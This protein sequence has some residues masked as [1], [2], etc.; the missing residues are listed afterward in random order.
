MSLLAAS[1]D[2]I[3]ERAAGDPRWR[4]SGRASM[5]ASV[6]RISTKAASRRG[7]LLLAAL[8]TLAASATGSLKLDVPN[9]AGVKGTAEI[10]AGNGDKAGEVAPGATIA[11]PPGKYRLVL[12]MVGGRITKDSVIIAAGRTSTV[13]IAN[14]AVLSV[15]VKDRD[16]KE[17]GFGVTVTGT[18]PPHDKVAEFPSGEAILMAP[19]QVDVKVDA[20]PQGY[21][22]HAVTLK[23]GERANL[24]L[25]EVMPAELIVHPQRA[26]IPLD[27]QT[28]VVVYKAGT[29]SQIGASEPGSEHRFKLEPGDYDVYVENHSGAG[30]PYAT[31]RGIHLRGG[32]TVERKIALDAAPGASHTSNDGGG[33]NH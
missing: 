16:G 2:S 6:F 9:S 29:Q 20:P 17:P 28:R 11:L 27:K 32:D 10:Y 12:P 23:P 22:W 8:I 30:A 15:A 24:E 7:A 25:N 31:D 14:A 26:Q 33:R 5:I 13:L 1:A 4:L 18:S 21:Y 3:K 19:G